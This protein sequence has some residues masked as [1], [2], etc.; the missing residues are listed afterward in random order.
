MVAT[1][2]SRGPRYSYAE[3]VLGAFT[4]VQR[5]HRRHSVHLATLRAQVKKNAEVHKDKLGPQWSNWV[6]KAV[7]KL[8][9][10]GVLASEPSGNVTMTPDG[11]KAMQ[12]ARRSI[13]TAKSAQPTSEQ[14]EQVLKHVTH[15]AALGQVRGIKRGRTEG[16]ESDDESDGD[17]YTPRARSRPSTKRTKAS[18][19]STPKGKKPISKM[20]KAELRAEIADLKQVH[21][22]DAFWRGTSPLTD[23]DNEEEIERLRDALKERDEELLTIRRELA[24][25][26]GQE[27]SGDQAVDEGNDNGRFMT[28]ESHFDFLPSSPTRP[29]LPNH[30]REKEIAPLELGR[31]QSGSLISPLSKRPTP[32]PSAHSGDEE[33]DLNNDD[34]MGPHDDSLITPQATPTRPRPRGR[35]EETGSI[36]DGE[37]QGTLFNK[38][39]AV[40]APRDGQ[41]EPRNRALQDLQNQLSELSKKHAQVETCLLE[42]ESRIAELR[43]GRLDDDRAVSSMKTELEKS[44]KAREAAEYRLGQRLAELEGNVNVLKDKLI[45]EQSEMAVSSAALVSARAELQELKA[46]LTSTAK[47]RDALG[48]ENLANKERA[49]ALG[50]REEKLLGQIREYETRVETHRREYLSLCDE[51]DQLKAENVDLKGKLAF[52]QSESRTYE[53]SLSLSNQQITEFE[54][55]ISQNLTRNTLITN[56]LAN[57]QS[58]L[59]RRDQTITDLHDSLVLQTQ[60]TSEQQSKLQDSEEMTDRLRDDVEVSRAEADSLRAQ[61]EERI[62]QHAGLAVDLATAREMNAGLY[63]KVEQH[64]STIRELT[65]ELAAARATIT[66]SEAELGQIQNQC[67]TLE[68]TIQ[69]RD[70]EVKRLVETISMTESLAG[71][72]RGQLQ[73]NQEKVRDLQT[74]LEA[75]Q[76]TVLETEASLS[77]EIS[78]RK[79]CQAGLDEANESIVDVKAESERVKTQLEDA[80]AGIRDLET[81]LKEVVLSRESLSVTL[82]QE[83]DRA[84]RIESDLVETVE[85]VHE[86]EREIDELRNSKDADALTI[87]NLKRTF[88]T[89]RDS[90]IGLLDNFDLELSTATSSPMPRRR[91][92]ESS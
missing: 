58:D 41:Q 51:L 17:V 47:E 65:Q 2:N 63:L 4:Q 83:E 23:I 56:Q 76:R 24:Q 26:S 77:T 1:K 69:S 81:K 38:K 28:P 73:A 61:L 42:R 31:T 21:R 14:E 86:A 33:E 18:V 34:V 45:A 13:I 20:T 80:Q 62:V 75:A 71:K 85:K 66:S 44:K 70:D 9:Q 59:E 15:L 6:G 68:A 48:T 22:K 12:N 91:L 43:D 39:S 10:E 36:A 67:Q 46:D 82:Q 25:G 30:I 50:R 49:Q 27:G 5:E 29:Y 74:Q 57:L 16:P 89:L 54:T 87:T 3:R 8:E 90:Q 37:R 11:K 55:T 35:L 19:V 64:E 92:V 40:S 7:H 52:A 72:V 84:R 79:R 88:A 60:A 32:A 78:E 53:H